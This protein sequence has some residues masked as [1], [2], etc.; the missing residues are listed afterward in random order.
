[1]TERST[2]HFVPASSIPDSLFLSPSIH[3]SC[4]PFLSSFH[5]YKSSSAGCRPQ[6]CTEGTWRGHSPVAQPRCLESNN[7][8]GHM[9][10]MCGLSFSKCDT[11][12]FNYS[13]TLQQVQHF[14][15]SAHLYS[16]R[17]D[18]WT[19]FSHL[20]AFFLHLW[21]RK[22]ESSCQTG[23]DERCFFKARKVRLQAVICFMSGN[24]SHVVPEYDSFEI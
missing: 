14:Y 4:Y 2:C 3:L 22:I 9:D 11:T 15:C 8:S 13:N 5:R 16:W 10:G 17:I 6:A 12:V 1:M 24:F 18:W 20:G 23:W 19:T 21:Q 7:Y